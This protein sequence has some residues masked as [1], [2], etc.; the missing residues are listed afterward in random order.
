M[1]RMVGYSS[2]ERYEDLRKDLGKSNTDEGS[3]WDKRYVNKKREKERKVNCR[4]SVYLDS[5]GCDKTENLAWC[6]EIHLGDQKWIHRQH[7]AYQAAVD[8]DPRVC[9]YSEQVKEI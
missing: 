6:D 2:V 3:D 5:E 1:D 4:K 8:E 7:G 9:P